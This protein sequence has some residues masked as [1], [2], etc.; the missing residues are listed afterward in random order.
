[1]LLALADDGTRRVQPSPNSRARCPSCLGAVLSKCGNV[2]CWHWAHEAVDDC[3][4][5]AK[6]ETAWHRDW[7]ERFPEEW[8]EVVVG[9][10]RADIRT[11]DGM[12]VEFQASPISDT[13]IQARERHY[14]RVIWVF[15]ASEAFAMG[16]LTIDAD[17]DM[18][19]ESPKK[20]WLVPARRPYLDVGDGWLWRPNNNVYWTAPPATDRPRGV[21]AAGEWWTAESFVDGIMER[22]K[23]VQPVPAA[24]QADLFGGQG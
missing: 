3:D 1:M 5:W 10:H 17:G 9:C 24:K 14:G 2:V 6:G 23:K 13:D 4:E 21:E 11:P 7:K 16:R 15:D 19:W 22:A 20:S 18:Q 8:R 12:T